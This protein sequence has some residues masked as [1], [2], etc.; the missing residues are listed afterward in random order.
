[1]TRRD[2]TGAAAVEL[3]LVTPLLVMLLLFVLFGGR[4]ASATADV[5]AAARASARAASLARDADT[6]SDAARATAEGELRRTGV[7][8]RDVVV[9][10]DTSG[11]AAGGSVTVE[12]HCG[13]PL[14]DLG[15]LGLPA[16]H[17][18]SVRQVAV[19]DRYRSAR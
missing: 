11:F 2:D 16:T 4:L 10:T 15:L 8:C 12:L 5:N 9:D 6:A 1:M 3:V 14:G 19:I 18:I 17:T 7:P 13:V